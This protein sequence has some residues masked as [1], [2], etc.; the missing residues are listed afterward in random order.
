MTLRG[1]YCLGFCDLG[2]SFAIAEQLFAFAADPVLGV[3]GLGA[4]CILRFG[5]LK[6]MALLSRLL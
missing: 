1:Y 2:R 5:L 3:T 6:R 4:G